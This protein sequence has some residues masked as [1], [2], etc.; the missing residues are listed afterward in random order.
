[1]SEEIKNI[2]PGRYP[3][4]IVKEKVEDRIVERVENKVL[5][6]CGLCGG[7]GESPWETSVC[8]ACLGEGVFWMEEPI[9]VCWLCRG[10]GMQPYTRFK[11][12][13]KVC[14]GKGVIKVPEGKECPLCHGTGYS[15]VRPSATC[16]MCKGI[17]VISE[18]PPVAV[19][20]VMKRRARDRK[21]ALLEEK[22]E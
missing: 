16:G 14:G 8:R 22:E 6:R 13:C 18:V 15:P 9:K 3:M 20:M 11:V 1:M 10:T 19:R 12:H 7:S 17:G 4:T 2:W 5:V 21:P